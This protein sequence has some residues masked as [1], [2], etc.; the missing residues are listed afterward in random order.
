MTE[1]EYVNAIRMAAR[2]YIS[3]LRSI[4]GVMPDGKTPWGQSLIESVSPGTLLMLCKSWEANR[5]ASEE[6]HR[7]GSQ[8]LDDPAKREL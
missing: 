1:A 4:Q 3:T 2:D 5:D 6:I 7:L 8:S